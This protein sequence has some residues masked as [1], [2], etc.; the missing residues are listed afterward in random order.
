M[1]VLLDGLFD[2]DRSFDMGFD[3]VAACGRGRHGRRLAFA[4]AFPFD[5]LLRRRL[6]RDGK[7]ER[8][9]SPLVRIRCHGQPGVCGCVS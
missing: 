7:K 1:L 4:A 3:F 6:V 8:Q 9:V 5:W 2:D